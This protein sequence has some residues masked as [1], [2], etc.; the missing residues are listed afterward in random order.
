MLQSTLRIKTLN[1]NN[2]EESNSGL[3]SSQGFAAQYLG[4]STNT[5]SG[6]DKPP[7][8]DYKTSI[9]IGLPI[10][11]IGDGITFDKD[12]EEEDYSKK[13]HDKIFTREQ[14]IPGFPPPKAPDESSGGGG[15]PGLPK[16]LQGRMPGLP[17]LGSPEPPP[18]APEP[19]PQGSPQEAL[20]PQ[21]LAQPPPGGEQQ[22]PPPQPGGD[23]NAMGGATP[24]Q[25]G[26]EQMAPPA[27]PNAMG[28]APPPQP[29]GDPNAMGGADPGLMA[30]GA[31]G[32]PVDIDPMTG[33][34]VRQTSEIGKIYE[35]KK[36]YSRLTTIES[37]LADTTDQELIEMRN[38]VGQSIEFFDI[39]TSNLQSY[40]DKIDTIIILFYDFLDQTYSLLADYFKEKKERYDEMRNKK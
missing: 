9:D 16:M 29:G 12:G 32:A 20:P 17:G 11:N 4:A 38:V 37:F 18:Q 33:T 1:P 23:P 22:A 8:T 39:V 3:Q 34:P 25:P 27:D 13:L 2:V 35:M 10:G 24:P 6:R 21:Q 36:I 26:G 31:P 7:D 5:A 14:G 19:P 28:G 30:A 15:M 40:K